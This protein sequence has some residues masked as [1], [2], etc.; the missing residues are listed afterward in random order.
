M[1]FIH[2]F[3]CGAS[4]YNCRSITLATKTVRKGDLIAYVGSTGNA[5]G[6]HLHIEVLKRGVAVNPIN[7]FSNW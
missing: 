1:Y 3:P 7:V 4:R 2:E 6:P 5:S